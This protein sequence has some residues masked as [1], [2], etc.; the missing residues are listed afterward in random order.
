MPG[1]SGRRMKF[2]F[3]GDNT[4]YGYSGFKLEE[5]F[6][7]IGGV[8]SIDVMPQTQIIADGR[9]WKGEPWVC[10]EPAVAL[11]LPEW[12]PHI[13]SP[14][15][16]IYTMW[17]GRGLPRRRVEM[18]NELAQLCIVPSRWC[19]DA[20]RSSGVT[21]PVVAVGM[22]VDPADFPEIDRSDHNGRPYRFL[23]NGN[24]DGR[25]NWHMV[26]KAFWQAF[27]G[28]PSAELTLHYRVIRTEEPRFTDMNVKMVEGYVGHAELL[29]MMGEADCYV[30]P[31]RAE[32]WGLGPREAA[33]TGLPA[34]VTEYAGLAEDTRSWGL[35]VR[36]CKEILSTFIG[37]PDEEFC[38]G[39][40]CYNDLVELMRW[41]Y[42]HREAAAL[43]GR[44]AA[45]WL[46]AHG[47]WDLCAQGIVDAV[48]RT[49]GE[50]C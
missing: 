21:I 39:E 36:V 45:R 22:G 9:D 26:Y 46:R 49:M 35:P 15:T 14:F 24:W 20:F 4:S 33:C 40:P 48:R 11:M 12:L 7:R 16:A 38:I 2:I 13:K 32:G 3:M 1:G 6:G 47:S 42:D 28:D 23:W 44:D 50:T 30:F 5:A 10:D 17:E 37:V 19:A 43:V 27:E 18:L 34:I 25:K 29:R 41:C 8:T 31:S